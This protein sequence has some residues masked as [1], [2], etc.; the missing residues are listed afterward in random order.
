MTF[1]QLLDVLPL[2]VNAYFMFPFLSV[3]VQQS[4][5]QGFLLD[6]QLE[7]R[8]ILHALGDIDNFLLFPF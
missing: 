3:V 7:R 1:L 6:L 8:T 5:R 4:I 2:D